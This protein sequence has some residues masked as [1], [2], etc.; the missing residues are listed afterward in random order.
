LLIFYLQESDP[1][2]N[3]YGPPMTEGVA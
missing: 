2:E 1:G 3:S